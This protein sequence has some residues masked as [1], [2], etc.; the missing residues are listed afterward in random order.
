MAMPS[1]RASSQNI[2][3]LSVLDNSNDMD[4]AMNSTAWFAFRYAV[5]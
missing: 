2:A 1:R 3:S 5:W 4:A